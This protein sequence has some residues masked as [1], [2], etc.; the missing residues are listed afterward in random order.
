[1]ALKKYRLKLPPA[2]Y[3]KLV[4]QVHKRDNHKCRCCKGRKLIS[5]HHILFRSH[6]GDDTLEN[7]ISLCVDC[8]NAVHQRELLLTQVDEDGVVVTK[9]INANQAVQFVSIRGWRPGVANVTKS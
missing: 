4:G 5:A 6:G 7:L 8:H 3:N 1:M 9:G 2:E